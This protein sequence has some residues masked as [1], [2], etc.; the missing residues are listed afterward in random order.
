MEASKKQ[1]KSA[2]AAKKIYYYT[3]KWF[4]KLRE[5]KNFL[6]AVLEAQRKERE[7][8][9]TAMHEDDDDLASYASSLE[10]RSVQSM[11]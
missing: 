4:S 5:K 1:L 11:K 10:S 8:I 7:G 3:M 9:Q 6:L 2:E